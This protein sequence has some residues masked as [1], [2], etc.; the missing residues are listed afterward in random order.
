MIMKPMSNKIMI[1]IIFC[2]SLFITCT[3]IAGDGPPKAT[4]PDQSSLKKVADVNGTPILQ[5]DFDAEF[6]QIKSRF[7]QKGQTIP[8]AQVDTAKNEVLDNLIDQELLHQES[9]K[10]G[11]TV[12]DTEISESLAKVKERFPSEAEFNKML[13]AMNLSAEGVSNKIKRS[14]AINK[15]VER[16]L[17]QK[18][19]VTDDETKGFYE[20]NP[21]SFS[22]PK[23]VKASHILV[24]TDA[25]SD[26][27]EKAKAKKKIA[28]I[29]QKIKNGEDFAELA[30]SNSDCP[31]G[32]KGGDL[33][34]FGAGSMVKPFEEAAFSMKPGEISD[35]VETQFG[36][37]LIKV[38]EQKE[39][40]KI[41]YQEAKENIGK[42]LK[43]KKT[44]DEVK[45]LITSIKKDAKIEKYL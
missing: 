34:F 27:T 42:Y 29:Q 44:E 22:Q 5:N 19:T 43:R 7:M 11:I 17:V 1:L 15:L 37:H 31:S 4:A 13:A 45:T 2:I 35:I 20:G 6:N 33:G 30:K 16:D 39:A 14:I 41:S 36:Y 24:K 28:S 3:V 8:P 26:E 12:N 10:R 38:T 25:Q 18:I 21:S 40:Q 23:Q 9:V 32:A